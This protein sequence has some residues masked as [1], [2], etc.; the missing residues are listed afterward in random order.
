MIVSYIV[1]KYS[2]QTTIDKSV[3]LGYINEL[4]YIMDRCGVYYIPEK[5]FI[6]RGFA[7]GGNLSSLTTVKMIRTVSTFGTF[8]KGL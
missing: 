7:W 4:T 3:K 2:I 6:Y 1:L 5:S 8:I